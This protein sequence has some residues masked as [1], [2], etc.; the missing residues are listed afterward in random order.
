MSQQTGWITKGLLE[1]DNC[2]DFY[3]AIWRRWQGFCLVVEVNYAET[4][5]YFIGWRAAG[6][7]FGGLLNGVEA[8]AGAGLSQKSHLFA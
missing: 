6:H 8:E 4:S 5:K 1:E 2:Q 7:E 3:E